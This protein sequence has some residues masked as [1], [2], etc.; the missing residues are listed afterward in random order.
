M[1]GAEAIVVDQATHRELPLGEVGEIWLQGPHISPGYIDNPAATAETFGAMLDTGKGP[2]LRTGDLAFAGPGGLYIVGRTK[3]LIIVR[4]RNYAPSDVEQLWSEISGTVGSGSTA[5]VQIDR[6]GDAHV[7]VIAEVKREDTWSLGGDFIQ[8]RARQLREAA[9]TRLELGVTDLVM[10]PEGSIPRTT[11][12]KVQRNACGD[13]VMN[14]QIVP[15]A[16]AGPLSSSIACRPVN[17]M[18]L[19]S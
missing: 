9:M 5:A 16:I 17:K 4:G 18:A 2:F 12:G 11:S 10:V 7:V 6:A 15:L 3:D 13:M 8:S 1:F 19:S 14:G